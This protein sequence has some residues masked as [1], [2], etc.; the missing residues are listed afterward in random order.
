MSWSVTSISPSV[1]VDG[2]DFSLS[3]I[4]DYPEHQKCHGLW[5]PSVPVCRWIAAIPPPPSII[6]D[7]SPLYI[8]ST[9]NV[10][11]RDIHQTQ[12]A[13]GRPCPPPPILHDHSPLNIL[14]TRNVMVRD[15]HQTQCASGQPLPPP[16]HHHLRTLT[17]EYPEHQKF[18]GPWHPSV[19]VCLWMAVTPL[20]L[21]SGTHGLGGLSTV[22][23]ISCKIPGLFQFF[24]NSLNYT[25]TC[26]G[27]NQV[28]SGKISKSYILILPH[29][30]EHMMS[31]KC[32]QPLDKLTV[33]VW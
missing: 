27:G 21:S 24:L 22:V 5:H 33:Q 7:H 17:P 13:S 29:P 25:L 3:I 31:V 19:P 9:R 18:H 28:K 2:L 6:C 14:S 23:L 4:C 11:V 15:I 26:P 1:S 16:L 10:M 30:Q 20:S 12:C 32:E 8:L